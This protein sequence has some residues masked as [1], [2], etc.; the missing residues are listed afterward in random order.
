M[1]EGVRVEGIILD[2]G[3]DQ[4]LVR[5]GLVPK[6]KLLLE[7]VELRCVHGDNVSYPLAMVDMDLDG[8]KFQ[9]KAGVA[10]DLPVPMLMGTNVEVI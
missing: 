4:I 1:V 10:D 6:G 8:K 2:T 3:C 9:V 5:K 7:T